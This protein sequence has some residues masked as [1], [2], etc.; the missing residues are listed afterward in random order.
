LTFVAFGFTFMPND[1]KVRVRTPHLDFSP[2]VGST[3]IFLSKN[4]GF[5]SLD[6]LLVVLLICPIG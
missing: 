4:Q 3:G 5:P 2:G 1:I 6:I